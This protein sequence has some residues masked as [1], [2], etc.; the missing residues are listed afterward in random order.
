MRAQ[1][2]A[3]YQIV[4]GDVSPAAHF[5]FRKNGR[6]LKRAWAQAL[7]V[8]M[9]LRKLAFI[10]LLCFGLAA[11]STPSQRRDQLKPYLEYEVQVCQPG[12]DSISGD[13]TGKFS[14]ASLFVLPFGKT[15]DGYKIY[16][17][18]LPE[19]DP[20]RLMVIAVSA[21]SKKQYFSFF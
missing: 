13:Q 3:S 18:D 7:C 5:C 16:Q 20:T 12:G 9:L 17:A 21:G 19:I 4:A 14:I 1:R 15:V 11:C 6:R 2:I 8:R 10:E